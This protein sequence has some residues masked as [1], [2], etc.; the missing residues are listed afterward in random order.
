M[1][2]KKKY[3]VTFNIPFPITPDFEEM[4]PDQRMAVHDLFLK[5]ELL[6]YTLSND[7]SKLWA[8][9]MA[10]SEAS[11]VKSIESLP[12]TDF[13]TYTISELM[14]HE[15]LQFIPTISMN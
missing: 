15:S 6:T 8:I 14:F 1:D 12:M 10:D 4:I 11:L 5:E 13:M 9:F 7:R 3:M 2:E